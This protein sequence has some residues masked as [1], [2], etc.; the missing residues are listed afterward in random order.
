VT[1]I[2]GGLKSFALFWWD[3]LVGDD[4]RIAAGVILALAATAAIATTSLPAWWLVP[5]AVAALLGGSLR[6]AIRTRR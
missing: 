3:F 6:S 2:A 4:W 1:R 5:I